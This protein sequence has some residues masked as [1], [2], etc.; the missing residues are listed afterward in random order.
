[1]VTFRKYDDINY[2]TSSLIG[3]MLETIPKQLTHYYQYV[4]V[5]P[6]PNSMSL[7][8][9]FEEASAN[10]EL[11]MPKDYC[12]KRKEEAVKEMVLDGVD[13]EVAREF[14]DEEGAPTFFTKLISKQAT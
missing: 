10:G 1:M 5:R 9:T 11:T 2:S 3:G 14:L 4:N 7:R 8:K 6:G 13:P 12:N